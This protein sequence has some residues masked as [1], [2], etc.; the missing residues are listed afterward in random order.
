MTT[1]AFDLIICSTNFFPTKAIFSLKW[2]Q[3][4]L[5]IKLLRKNLVFIT[6]IVAVLF[7]IT[8]V[9]ASITA[10]PKVVLHL[11]V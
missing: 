5:K 4:T 3:L 10:S 9:L 1:S 6:F 7:L 8:I 2:A 11:Q